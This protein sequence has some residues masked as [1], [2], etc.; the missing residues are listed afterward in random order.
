M[1]P[2]AQSVQSA[3][4]DFGFSVDAVR[5][6]RKFWLSNLPAEKLPLLA[7]KVL[8]ND[9]IEQVV[10]GPLKFDRLELGGDYAFQL[11]TV[12]LLEMDDTALMNLSRSGQ[13]FLSLAEMQTI[14]Q[15][16]PRTWDAIRPMSNWKRWPKRGASI[17][18]TRRW[19]GGFAY[20]AIEQWPAARAQFDNMLKETIFA[21]TQKIR[22][23]R[24]R[25]G[26]TIGAS[27][28]SK[29]TP[30]SCG[31]TINSTWRSK[32]KRTIIPSALEPYGGANTGV[33][34]VIR[35]LMGT[36]LGREADLQH[37]C[38]LLRPPRHAGRRVAAGRASSAASDAGR[39]RRRARLRQP[40]GNSRRSTVPFIS[41][42]RY[43]GNPLV[44][45]GNVGLLPR[46]KSQ[47]RAEAGRSDRGRRRPHR[48]RRHSRRDVQ[49][50]RAHQRK[51]IALRRRGAD[52]QRH[53]EKMV[54]DVLLAARDR[55]LFNAVTDC[56]AGGFSSA[57]GEMGE[58]IGA[59]VWLDRAPLKYAGL[60]YTEIWISEAQER[61]VLAV[62]PKSVAGV[63][64]ACAGPKASK[65]RP[66][67]DF[68]PTRPTATVLSR[69]TGRRLG[70]GVLAQR[71]AAGGARRRC[72]T[73]S[74]AP[75]NLRRHRRGEG[76]PQATS[77]TFRSGH[78]TTCSRFSASPN[79]AARNGSFGNTITKCKAAAS[80][81]PFVGVDNDGPSDA[82]VLRPVLSLAARRRDCLRHESAL[83]RFRSRTTWPP[84]RSTKQC[85]T[86]W[87]SAPI[88]SGSRFSTIS[89]GAIANG[90]KRSASLVR[91]A[92]GLPRRGGRARHAVHQRQR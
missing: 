90:Q 86:A 18:A 25:V 31:S 69:T 63:G 66:S 64:I 23:Q 49:F 10:V 16:L 43:L 58:K 22:E 91:A 6:L 3:I 76:A 61:M 38:V 68:V 52:R 17:A 24:A 35:D 9:A 4:A 77:D 27:A 36:G 48:S 28:C 87:Q 51:R 50:G 83:W 57:V 45:C 26:T 54:L 79:V 14:Q 44:Y 32:S 72:T 7:G 21:A 11:V 59:E 53:Y 39:R 70:D 47:Q 85:A 13:L 20:T 15:P 29:T 74:V 41:I 75:S 78:T 92:L 80:M 67:A 62:P 8:A 84:A 19:P 73:P 82:A 12:K 40:D 30:A 60:S 37:R 34:G 2:V 88:R 1:D 46:D 5:T 33:G 89:A 42:E 81:K 56:G 71:P 55:G 65:R